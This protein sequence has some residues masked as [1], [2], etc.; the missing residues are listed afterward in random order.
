M[1]KL[2]P[3]VLALA[4][5]SC[6]TEIVR[7]NLLESP[8][9]TL[10]VVCQKGDEIFFYLDA[11]MEF[12]SHPMMVMDFEFYKGKQLLLKGGIDPLIGSAEK[13]EI[14]NNNGVLHAE[15]YKKLE[16]SFVAPGDTI[17]TIRPTLVYN[18]TPNLKIN[19]LELVFVR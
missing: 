8:S 4:L 11:D 12:D 13:N 5:F 10:D 7:V 3:I 19:K 16:G 9:P 14:K 18:N 2:V 15:I 1:I 6:T 17:Y